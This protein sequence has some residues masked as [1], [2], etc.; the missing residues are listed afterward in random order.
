[1]PWRYKGSGGIAP[2]VLNLT[3]D[4]NQWS[5]SHPGIWM[6]PTAGPEAAEKREIFCLYRGTDPVPL[7]FWPIIHQYSNV[8]S[9]FPYNHSSN[10]QNYEVLKLKAVM[11]GYRLAQSVQWQATS[12]TGAFRFPV[13]VRD[14]PPFHSSLT[15]SGANPASYPLGTRDFLRC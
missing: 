10:N 13:G 14:L 1:M 8:S 2:C 15:G 4:K 12:W 5:A 3:L 11:V 7:A 9:P 6:G